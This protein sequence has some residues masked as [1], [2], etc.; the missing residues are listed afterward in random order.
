MASFEPVDALDVD[1]V[2]HTEWDEAV[3]QVVDI[4]GLPLHLLEGSA[5]LAPF[6]FAAAAESEL[7]RDRHG[8]VVGRFARTRAPITGMVRVEATQTR[9]RI[10]RSSR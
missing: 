6:S 4:P 2:V 8:T 10:S 7:I 5:R 1:G 9:P 3:E